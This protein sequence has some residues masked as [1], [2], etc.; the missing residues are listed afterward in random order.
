MAI[1][2]SCLKCLRI[3]SSLKV[4]LAFVTTS[5]ALEIFFIATCW[6]VYVK[7]TEG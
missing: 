5:K 4:R 6:P 3:L 7:D 2:L 1:M